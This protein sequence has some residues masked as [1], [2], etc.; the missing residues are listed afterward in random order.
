MN[1]LG[2]NI[3][4]LRK[5]K[6]MTQ[7]D[8]ASKINVNRSLIGAY[9]EGRSE[10]RLNTIQL[11]CSYFKVG[12]QDIITKDLSNLD[13]EQKD[14]EGSKLRVLPIAVDQDGGEQIIMI[15]QKASA[16]YTQGYSDLGFIENLKTAQLPFQELA[17][18][19]TH[20]IFQIQ[21][22]SMLPTPSGSY[23]IT[24]YVENWRDIQNNE[25]Y[26]L[27]TESDGVVYKRVLNE[28]ENSRK[29]VLQS[30][31]TEYAPYSIS[32]NDVLEVWKAKGV[33]SFEVP[34][35]E[36][37]H[38]QVNNKVMEVVNELKMEVKR[39]HERLDNSKNYS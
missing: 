22:D 3:R 26:V 1:F 32:I 11:L 39:L 33:L 27:L 15:P 18:E 35:R 8:L 23:I 17:T 34:D 12:I 5:Q 28:I 20:R 24:E 6:E 29:L 4:L 10:P 13:E 25:C 14:V 36:T 21:G 19:R 38:E 31:N 9:E 2:S 16:G 7:A 37:Y 30:D